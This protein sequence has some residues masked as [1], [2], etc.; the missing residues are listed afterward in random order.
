MM[1]RVFEF[2]LLA[3]LIVGASCSFLF[4]FAAAFFLSKQKF[5]PLDKPPWRRAAPDSLIATISARKIDFVAAL[6]LF[7]PGASFLTFPSLKSSWNIVSFAEN[8]GPSFSPSLDRCVW[9]FTERSFFP[10]KVASWLGG[11]L[12]WCFFLSLPF[13]IGVVVRLPEDPFLTAVVSWP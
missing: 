7:F 11:S 3:L 1:S 8:D 12:C 6:F 4:L 5:P 2:C 9:F 10:N 13:F